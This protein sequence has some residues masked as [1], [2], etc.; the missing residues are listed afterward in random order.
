MTYISKT[1]QNEMIITV[2]AVIVN[3][4]SRKIRDSKYFSTTSD[5]AAYTD[6]EQYSD[7]GCVCCTIV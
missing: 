6:G 1:I 7:I 5:E 2:G 3:N 4:L